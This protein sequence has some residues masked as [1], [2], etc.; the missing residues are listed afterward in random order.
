M[1]STVT[2]RCDTVAIK[3]GTA[4]VAGTCATRTCPPT[5]AHRCDL[6][7][8][9]AHAPACAGGYMRQIGTVA[10]VCNGASRRGPDPGTAKILKTRALLID[11]YHRLVRIRHD[12]RTIRHRKATER[13]HYQRRH[14]PLCP[15]EKNRCG[16]SCTISFCEWQPH[17]HD[18]NRSE[19]GEG[20]EPR[21][22]A[23]Q[24]RGQRTV[25][26]GKSD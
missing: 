25:K 26:N 13:G 9:R 19:T 11:K 23:R 16:G 4:T 3:C 24:E 6:P 18:G 20:V 7:R 21:I 5:V 10:T 12:G 8:S 2:H 1:I 17:D 14:F 22:E 15:S